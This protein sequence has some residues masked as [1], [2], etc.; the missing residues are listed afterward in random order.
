MVSG[1]EGVRIQGVVGQTANLLS[2]VNAAGTSLFAYDGTN[3]TMGGTFTTTALNCGNGGVRLDSS[4][5][6]IAFGNSMV[7]QDV[8]NAAGGSPQAGLT[9]PTNGYVKVIG[10]ATGT[11]GVIYTGGFGMGYRTIS[12][13]GS[14]L[15]TT[16]GIANVTTSNITFSMADSTTLTGRTTI[17]FNSSAGTST[18]QGFTS[19]QFFNGSSITTLSIP[20]GS[21]LRLISTGTT[22]NSYYTY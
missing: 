3:A 11:L 12:T 10:A 8:A 4:G 2:V 5:V 9:T 14:S 21:S 15:T 17:I 22:T 18:V 19:T 7:F 6:H 13:T 1:R 16:D 20:S